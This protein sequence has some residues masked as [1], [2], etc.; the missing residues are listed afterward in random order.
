MAYYLHEKRRNYYVEFGQGRPVVLLHGI[1]NSGRAWSPQIARLV[2]T[3]FRVIVPDHAGHGASARI[4]APLGIED[5]AQDVI[6]LLDHLDIESAHLVGLSLGGLIAIELALTASAR[7]DTLVLANS[8]PST[9]TDAF[10]ALAD[11]WASTFRGNDGPVKRFEGAWPSNVSAPFRASDAGI[12]TWQTWHAIAAMA[13][14]ESLAYIA[15]GIVGYD[16]TNRLSTIE[17]PTL[18]I[19]GSDDR[20][21]PP[22]IS[23]DMSLQLQCAKYVEI[24]AAAHISNVDSA[25]AFNA[26]M[27]AFLVGT[28]SIAQ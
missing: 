25:D 12:A 11:Q 18:V 8:F 14:G 6:A 19:A 22:S 3:G 20:I 24:E 17:K 7:V 16:S 21:S 26:E 13:D 15:Q 27:I 2:E 23:R 4:G 1:S 5:L 9:S 28:E 10:R